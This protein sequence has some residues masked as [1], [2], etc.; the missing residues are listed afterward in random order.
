MMRKRTLG[1]YAACAVATGAGMTAG[2]VV[3]GGA[4]E[5]LA[6]EALEVRPGSAAIGARGR[7]P[8]PGPAWAV[9]R[10]TSRTGLA[11]T[12]AGRFDGRRFGLARADGTVREVPPNEQGTCVATGDDPVQVV[13]NRYP[14]Q[15]GEGDRTVLFGRAD[16]GVGRIVVDGPSGPVE[17]A[18][19]PDGTFVLVLAG[20]LA[21][22]NLP[23]VATMPDGRTREYR[24]G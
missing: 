9:R 1:L 24:L 8:K 13:V 16:P 6:P 18:R 23:L 17:P 19:A 3:A 7:D 11:C 20:I 4:P 14:A 15:A 21:P 2:G 5:P 22:E 12:E 10:Y